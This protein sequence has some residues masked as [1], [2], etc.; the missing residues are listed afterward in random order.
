M[1]SIIGLIY[2][3]FNYFWEYSEVPGL[4]GH[5]LGLCWFY[6]LF[7]FIFLSFRATLLVYGD[8]QARGQ[9]GA[10]APGLHHSHSNSGSELHL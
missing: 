3:Y 9:I 6:H 2:N 1:V 4:W 7:Y 5:R 8:S 10:V